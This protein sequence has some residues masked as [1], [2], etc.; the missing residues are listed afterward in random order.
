MA[1]WAYQTG[2]IF[3]EIP[4]NVKWA[5]IQPVNL[6]RL[7]CFRTTHFLYS[8]SNCGELRS[9]SSACIT[10][11]Q[12]KIERERMGGV[13]GIVLDSSVLL[14]SADDEVIGDAGLCSGAE[15]LL[16]KL[17]Y[18]SIPIVNFPPIIEI[19]RHLFFNYDNISLMH[20]SNC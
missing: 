13:R 4:P 8:L 5:G 18:S 2:P 11:H 10:S 3:T 9:S 20:V 16:R 15:Y 1:Q 14:P 12:Q 7:R 19:I 6:T 17:R